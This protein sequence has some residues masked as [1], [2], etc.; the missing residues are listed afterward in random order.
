MGA[1]ESWA[2]DEKYRNDWAADYDGTACHA[3]QAGRP[4]YRMATAAIDCMA[5]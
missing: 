3:S 4:R 2:E 5:S 1:A